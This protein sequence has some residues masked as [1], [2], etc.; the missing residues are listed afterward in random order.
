MLWAFAMTF[1][2]RGNVTQS[3]SYTGSL[4]MP[5][6]RG[7]VGGGD[8]VRWQFPFVAPLPRWM[9]TLIS[10]ISA[11]ILGIGRISTRVDASKMEAIARARAR[12]RA[13]T[14]VLKA[15][16]RR[17]VCC[18]LVRR[19]VCARPQGT[20]REGWRR[21]WVWMYGSKRPRGL[22]NEYESTY[23]LL[24]AEVHNNI[25]QSSESGISIG[26]DERGV[27]DEARSRQQT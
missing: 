2:N 15:S 26:D 20:A 3:Y 23:A 6:G 24:S 1:T 8:H 21:R 4:I 11:I 7:R 25:F 18:Q 10:P 19:Q 12:Q 13:E 14:P 16:Q 9:H 22:T 27:D 5:R 17:Q